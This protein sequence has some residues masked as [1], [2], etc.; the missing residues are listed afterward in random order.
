MA[1]GWREQYYR[2]R[3]FYLNIQSLYKQRADV[4][5]FLEIILSVSTVIIFLAFALRPTAL[6]IISLYGQIQEKKQTTAELAQKLNDLQTAN[7]VFANNQSFAP[8]V[9][10]AI[11]NA[12]KPDLVTE[13]IQAL[14]AKDS[15]NILGISIGDIF[16][17]GSPVARKPAAG[18]KPLPDGA[19]EMPISISIKGSYQSLSSFLKD[20]ENL[21]TIIN[22]DSVGI[23]SST[24][25][26]GQTIVSVIA[27]RAPYLGK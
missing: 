3:E 17:S 27:G 4:R 6:T 5:A 14:S 22:L 20:L 8:D 13:Q 24:S 25:S 2:Y 26:Q 18:T 23:S 7:A 10:T 19:L 16:V 21:R 12:P 15:V 1:L 11:N 9:D